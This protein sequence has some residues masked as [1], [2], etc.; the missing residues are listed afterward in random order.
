[1]GTLFTLVSRSAQASHVV[2]AAKAPVK[3]AKK[4]VAKATKAVKKTASKAKS[5]SGA[6]FWYGA[7]RPGFLGEYIAPCQPKSTVFD[8]QDSSQWLRT[9]DPML[10]CSRQRS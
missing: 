8:R 6:A 1:M 5:A 9:V 4:A 2:E 10:Q 3:T 7:D